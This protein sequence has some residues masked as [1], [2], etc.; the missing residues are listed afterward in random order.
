MKI[1]QRGEK[2]VLLDTAGKIIE[3][4]DTEGEAQA[5]LDA[6]QGCPG[7]QC[8]Q[9]EPGGAPFFVDGVELDEAQVRS[10]ANLVARRSRRA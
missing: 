8:H 7:G 6:K 5:A 4:Y 2:W 9:R 1:E 10:L 3:T